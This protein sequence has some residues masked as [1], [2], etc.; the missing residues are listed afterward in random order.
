MSSLLL[1]PGG[2]AEGQGLGPP[3]RDARYVQRRV[4]A[5]NAECDDCHPE[6]DRHT[7]A[8]LGVAPCG[9][10]VFPAVQGCWHS[11]RLAC[12]S[13]CVWACLC[14]FMLSYTAHP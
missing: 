10:T 6:E 4:D 14:L 2:W 12:G 5:C 1:A 9:I 7:T 8:K 3:G 13:R 11:V